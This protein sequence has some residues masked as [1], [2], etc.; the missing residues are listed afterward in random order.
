MTETYEIIVKEQIIESSFLH[1]LTLNLS[2]FIYTN[3][4]YINL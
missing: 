2:T 1:Q 4:Q 3:I